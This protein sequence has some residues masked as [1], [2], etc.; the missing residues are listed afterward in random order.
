[1]NAKIEEAEKYI[2]EKNRYL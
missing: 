2:K 1:M